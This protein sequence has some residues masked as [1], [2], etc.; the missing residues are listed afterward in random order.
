VRAR[1]ASGNP[2]KLEEL[3]A[4]LPGWDLALLEADRAYPPEDGATYLENARG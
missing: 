2:H 4:S 1:L 3:Q